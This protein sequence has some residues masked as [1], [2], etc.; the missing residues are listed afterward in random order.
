MQRNWREPHL[1]IEHALETLSKFDLHKLGVD[2]SSFEG[3]E[4]PL[5][6]E[7]MQSAL[8]ALKADCIRMERLSADRSWQVRPIPPLKQ[9]NSG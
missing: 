6:I 7:D 4:F 5:L 3:K 1:M 2:P 8:R 9:A